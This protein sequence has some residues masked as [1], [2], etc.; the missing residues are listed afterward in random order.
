MSWDGLYMD[1]RNYPEFNVG[2]EVSPM[3][4]YRSLTKGNP[5]IV[6]EIFNPYPHLSNSNARKIKI[7]TDKGFISEYATYNFKKTERQIREDKINQILNDL[8]Y[9]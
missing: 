1:E 3:K 9:D 7:M 5:Y 6:L 4:K 8:I 2:D